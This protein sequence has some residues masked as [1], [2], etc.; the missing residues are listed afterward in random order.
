MPRPWLS[1]VQMPSLSPPP[2][3]VCSPYAAS[4]TESGPDAVPLPFSPYAASLAESGPDAVPL[5]SPF[6]PFSPYA[7]SL[8]E[9]G[10]DAV[11]LP[12]PSLR[13]LTL[14]RVPG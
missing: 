5:P 13:L 11:P 6:L 9:S 10:P 4:L 14:C 2:L 12:S 3:S 7:A 1:R 8:A